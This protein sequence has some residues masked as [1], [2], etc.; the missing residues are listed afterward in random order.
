[1][2]KYILIIIVNILIVNILYSQ[3]FN[4][5]NIKKNNP[6]LNITGG[7]EKNA[8]VY[9]PE[10]ENE[11]IWIVDSNQ[12]ISLS[13]NQYLVI[14]LHHNTPFSALVYIEFFTK[15]SKKNKIVQ[16]GEGANADQISPD[17]FAKIGVLPGL[18]TQL[19]LPL[20]YLD[21]Q[22]IFMNR[23]P[24]QMKGMVHGSRVLPENVTGIALRL[25]PYEKGS[26][27][28]TISIDSIFISNTIPTPLPLLKN[29]IVDS[30]GQWKFREWEGKTKNFNEL[31]TKLND[32][33]GK[34]FSSFSKSFSKYGGCLDLRFDSTGYF[35]TH[36]DGRRWWLV[37][38]EGYAFLS[39]GIDCMRANVEGPISGNEDVF[40]N[41]SKDESLYSIRKN[42]RIFNFLGFNMKTIWGEK[43]EEKWYKT[44]KSNMYK[45]HINTI[46][47]W[48]APKFY[49]TA[50]MPFV[51]PMDSFPETKVNLFRDFPDVFSNEY[52]E[53]TTK[54][55]QQLNRFKNNPYLIGYFLENEPHW[56]FGSFNLCYEMFRTDL[57]SDTKLQFEIWVKEKYTDN[58]ENLNKIWNSKFA[59]FSEIPKMQFKAEF[60][61][62][63]SAW[64]DM[65]KFT[66]V[67]VKKYI[68][69]LCNAVKKVD[70]QHL[71]LGM[72]YAWISSDLCY[73]AGAYFD[74]FSINGYSFP[75]PPKTE[76]ITK[77][78]NKPVLIGE[79][80]FGSTDRGLSANGIVGA[81][82]Q[83]DRGL[84]YRRYVE[85]GFARPELIGIHYFQWNDQPILG[86]GDG[87]NYNIGLFDV[88]N[89]PYKDMLDAMDKSHRIIYDIAK[90]KKKPFSKIIKKV[91]AI[92][93]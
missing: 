71:N 59:S 44:V 31:K 25:F 62:S 13:S 2:K 28:S 46:G 7:I 36:N 10:S 72:R 79:F 88:C 37:D 15:Y 33:E 48:S 22:N 47:N 19:I 78:T 43:W 66:E 18:P 42:I 87:E 68:E 73:L 5:Q 89:Q 1:M 75:D 84:A 23:F 80:H 81:A 53:N 83:K 85:Q 54:F 65:K 16:Q 52:I 58:L 39:A 40:D 67:M 91:P 9:K 4:L 38:P 11:R 21:G 64:K 51:Y 69:V 77:R 20:S 35:H 34:L 14:H 56:A 49:K 90:G 63:D 8:I 60:F 41:I 12:N 76:E 61:Y 86:R 82:N 92:Y 45:Y 93:Y 29:T 6:K 3:S 30:L 57:Q 24:R 17:L 55:A 74:V 70:N 32:N 27:E 50:Q 26:F